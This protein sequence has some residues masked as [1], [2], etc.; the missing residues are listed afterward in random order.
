MNQWKWNKIRKYWLHSCN[1]PFV[2]VV[3]NPNLVKKTHLYIPSENILEI[4]CEDNYDD[5]VCKIAYGVDAMIQLFNPKFILKI[6]DD[7]IVDTTQLHKVLLEMDEL[8][9]EFNQSIVYCGVVRE[10]KKQCSTK[11][12]IDKYT[13]TCNQ[14][15]TKIDPV[16]YCAGP[17]YYLG[18]EAMQILQKYMNPELIKFED[19][20]VGMTLNKYG[21]YP[22]S[23]IFYVDSEKEFL[24]DKS[25]GWHDVDRKHVQNIM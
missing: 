8:N 18:K 4:G 17:M 9:Q 14:Q 7:I 3:G 16:S 6:D 12:G 21:I 24:L 23:I 2:F 1:I 25:V 13:R 22:H 10:V 5:L 20:N 19:V 11:F 15:I